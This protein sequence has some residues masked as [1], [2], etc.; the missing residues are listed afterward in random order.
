MTLQQQLAEK[1]HNV[2]WASNYFYCL[3]PKHD[4]R[5]NSMLIWPDYFKCYGCGFQGPLERLEGWLSLAPLKPKSYVQKLAV[6]PKWRD[7][8]NRYD[9]LN[10]IAH[11]A[12]KRALKNPGYFTRTREI[13]EFMEMGMFGLLDGWAL[14]PV[15][16]ADRN[17]IDIVVRG[18]RNGAKYVVMPRDEKVPR[19]LYIPNM[20]RTLKNDHLYVVFGII[21]A[22]ALEAIGEPVV[23]GITGK[24]INPDLFNGF[25][26]PITI[27]PDWNEEREALKLA[28]EL[29]WR[30][31]V[32]LIN[33]DDECEDIDDVRRK[34][35]N[36]KLKE[37]IGV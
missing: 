14:F 1:L 3:C 29:G 13:G 10:G 34:Y 28:S 17:V 16:D 30:G 2:R 18:I 9:D 37:L 22:W 6:L 19:P 21:T 8:I 11:V 33:W 5:R 24:S 27:I 7:W 4:D 26:V 15:F 20:D 31:N 36:H 35:G 32:K 25:R 12:H 23:T